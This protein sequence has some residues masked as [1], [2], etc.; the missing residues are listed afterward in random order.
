MSELLTAAQMR[1]IEQAAIES[2]E[3]TGLELM[4]RAGQGVVEAIFEEWP[5]VGGQVNKAGGQPP[6]PRDISGMRMRAVVL[7]GPGNNGG[8]GFVVARLLHEQGWDVEVFLYGDAEKLPPD[9]RVNYERWCALGEVKDAVTLIGQTVFR[10]D[11]AVDGL[12]G[13]GLARPLD[14]SLGKIRETLVHYPMGKLVAIDGVSGVDLDSG[15][16]L[17]QQADLWDVEADLTVT[18]HAAKLGHFLGCAALHQ[19]K[20]VVADIGIGSFHFDA[21]HARAELVDCSDV[22]YGLNKGELSPAS[23]L[24]HKFSHGHALILSGG[25]GQ[26]G[27]ARLAARG[28]AA[29]RGRAGDAGGAAQCA[30]GGGLSDHRTYVEKGSRWRTPI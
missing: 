30:T 15:R 16:E 11:L 13:T 19:A 29:Y 12:F 8:D 5:E 22:I 6:D 25:S 27:A 21:G 10:F 2:G 28:G 4:E 23:H 26:T 7:C 18:F 17:L 20:V 14:V 9:A 3:V 24:G 1:A